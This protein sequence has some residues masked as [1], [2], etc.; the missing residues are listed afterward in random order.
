MKKSFTL[1]EM[2]V[3]IGIIAILVTLGF[4]AYSTVQK[5]ARDAKRQGD[6][7]TAQQVMEQ[8]YTVNGYQYPDFTTPSAGKFSVV[9]PTDAN[10]KF[11]IVDPI[12]S[13]TYIYTMV[14]TTATYTITAPDLE[15]STDPFSVSNQQ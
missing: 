5:K 9:C 14:R 7:K 3:V 11:T 4:A 6:L 10:L 13:G 2:L 1:L 12:N 8:C 15:S